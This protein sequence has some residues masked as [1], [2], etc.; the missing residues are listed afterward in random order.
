MK[1]N[2]GQPIARVTCVVNTCTHWENGNQ[3]QASSIKIEPPNA[4]S[5]QMTDCA[6]FAA[7]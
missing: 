7:K 3:C 5:A 1:A 4:N 6:T 2:S